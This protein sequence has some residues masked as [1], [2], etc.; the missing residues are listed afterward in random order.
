MSSNPHLITN[1]STEISFDHSLSSTLSFVNIRDYP[2]AFR[3]QANAPLRY[4]ITP[5][6]GILPSKSSVELKINTVTI[7]KS[8]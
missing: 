8:H 5:P 4:T 2:V 6:F 1:P 7:N 3:I